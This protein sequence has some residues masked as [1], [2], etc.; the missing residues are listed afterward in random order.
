MKL[1]K[2]FI[3][4]IVF[5]FSFSAKAQIEDEIKTFVD[6][7]EFI[8]NNGRQ[9]LAKNLTKGKYSKVQDIYN[10]LED[11]TKNNPLAA[12]SYHEA[13][14]INIAIKNWENVTNLMS[15]YQ[16]LAI[17][18]IYNF[19]YI[20]EGIAYDHIQDNRIAI[21]ENLRQSQIDK[22]AKEILL[23]LFSYFETETV[24][25]AY[26]QKIRSFEKANPNSVYDQFVYNFLPKPSY[27][28]GLGVYMGTGC[29]VP[30]SMFANNFKPSASF[31]MS[32]DFNYEDIYSSLYF[33]LAGPKLKKP[34]MGVSE[35]DSL[36][37]L[38]NETFIYFN[39]GLKVGYFLLRN[40]RFHIA[41][42]TNIG[43]TSLKSKRFDSEDEREDYTIA[44]SF[45]SGAGLHSEIKILEYS[46]ENNYG[47]E[48]LGYFSVKMDI[49]YNINFNFTDEN[50]KGNVQY[51]SFGLVWGTGYF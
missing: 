7:T 30:T 17:K 41:S 24:D 23:L 25:D 45:S 4:S 48:S 37:F 34:F 26:N 46:N 9:L 19:E 42:Y 12:F 2:Y 21:I 22:Q 16:T 3:I 33:N 14:Y 11:S 13:L 35:T 28:I 1:Y 50:F 20:L 18:D 10:Y 40:N 36:D 6:S 39:G 8:V 47:I 51:V 15:N 44:S 32:I 31:G 38:N 29:M 5:L 27:K 49:G 43:Y